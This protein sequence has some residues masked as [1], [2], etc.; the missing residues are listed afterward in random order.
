MRKISS[1]KDWND[2]VAD[3][4][5][6]LGEDGGY[7]DGSFAV[8]QDGDDWNGRFFTEFDTDSDGF[9]HNSLCFKTYGENEWIGSEYAFIGM[10]RYYSFPFY[11]RG[12]KDNFTWL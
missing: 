6:F 9:L 2:F 5:Y 1:K 8:S 7:K 11:I 10:T 3:V 12:P 4:E